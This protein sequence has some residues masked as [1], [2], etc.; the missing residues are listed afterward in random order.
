MMGANNSLAS[1]LK[2]KCPNLFL[3]K[4]IC[5]SFHLCASYACEKLPNDV[6]QL[7]KD[8]YNFFSNSSKRID[9]YKEFQEFAN[10]FPYKILHPSQE[11][12]F[13]R[14]GYQKIDFTI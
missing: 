2:E 4:C 3:M 9:Q 6:E 1:R 10:V 13:P 14:I 11:M 8:V 7:A 5:H 12:A